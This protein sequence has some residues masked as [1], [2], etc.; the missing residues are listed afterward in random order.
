MNFMSVWSNMELTTHL[1]RHS[2]SSSTILDSHSITFP[3]KNETGQ[4]NKAAN[5]QGWT[6]QIPPISTSNHFLQLMG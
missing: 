2:L 5:Q 4:K 1:P 6:M 3:I